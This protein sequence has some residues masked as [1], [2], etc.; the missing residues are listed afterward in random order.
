MVVIFKTLKMNASTQKFFI[1][2][3]GKNWLNFN[4]YGKARIQISRY[5]HVMNTFL[6]EM[7]VCSTWL[8]QKYSVSNCKRKKI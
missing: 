5:G 7:E 3:F 6:C 4:F 8:S 1:L 2:V